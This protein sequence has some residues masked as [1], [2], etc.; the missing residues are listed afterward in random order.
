LLTAKL[1]LAFRLLLHFLD[2]PRKSDVASV[3]SVANTPYFASILLLLLVH[4][5]V[6]LSS[7]IL[8]AWTMDIPFASVFT[9]TTAGVFSCAGVPAIVGSHTD[10]TS[11][12]WF[13][14]VFL[15]R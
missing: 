7:D 1:L 9:S 6:C 2:V 13:F 10:A 11:N 8:V 4:V 5:Q 3:S 14:Y 15:I 12:D